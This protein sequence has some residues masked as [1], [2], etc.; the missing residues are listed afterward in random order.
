MKTEEA[1]RIVENINKI[2]F[3]EIPNPQLKNSRAL[4]H[5]LNRIKELESLKAKILERLPKESVESL[6][7]GSNNRT[8]S[9]NPEKQDIYEQG[10]NDTIKEI[11]KIIEEV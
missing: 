7:L 9:Y 4:K 1:I 6:G 8:L 3:Q 10:R 5:L 2:Y 11:K